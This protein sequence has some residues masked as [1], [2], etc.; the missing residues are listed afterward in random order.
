MKR[1]G[2]IIKPTVS[3]TT[4]LLSAVA[5]GLLLLPVVRPA[6]STEPEAPAA[7]LALRYT[8]SGV[9]DDGEKGSSARKEATSI[10]CTNLAASA[11]TIEVHVYNWNGSE[12]GM[13]S[14]TA[15]AN[16][17]YTFSTQNTTIYFDDVILGDGGGTPAIFQGSGQVW[18]DQANVVCTVE[19]LDPL[20]YPPVFMEKLTMFTGA[21]YPV[22]VPFSDGFESGDTSRWSNS[23][24]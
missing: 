18:T 3:L 9:T 11:T 19:V 2:H 17:S 1:N 20:G 23:V 5:A 21:G 12:V 4:V 15:Q 10:L 8:F 16:S 14:V 24:P 13:G 22:G 6:Q 7:G